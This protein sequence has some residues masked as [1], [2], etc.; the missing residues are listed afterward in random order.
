MN[1]QK[2]TAVKFEAKHENVVQQCYVLNKL[3]ATKASILHIAVCH[4]SFQIQLCRMY[5]IIRDGGR[6]RAK[7]HGNL[8]VKLT[9]LVLEMK[10]F[11]RTRSTS[12]LLMHT[13]FVWSGHQK[14]WSRLNGS[15]YF[16]RQ[17]FT[18][19]TIPVLIIYMRCKYSFSHWGRGEKDAIS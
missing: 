4:W 2:Q 14:P 7:Q 9:L 11:R 6:E 5:A 3:A 8:S 19:C 18:T 12:L 10:Y 17:Y 1:P 16:P 15:L 13:L